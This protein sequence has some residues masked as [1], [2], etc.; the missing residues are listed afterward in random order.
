MIRQEDENS[1]EGIEG[2]FLELQKE[3][4]ELANSKMDYNSVADESDR[5]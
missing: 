2:K 5:L 3:L 4:L 1:S